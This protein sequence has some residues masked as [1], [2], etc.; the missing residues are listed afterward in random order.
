MT[1]KRYK[2]PADYSPAEHL[3]DLQ[4]RPGDRPRIETPAYVAK[5]AEALREAGFTDEAAEVEAASPGEPTKIEDMAP[6]DHYR[7]L[8]G[9][10]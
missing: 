1:Q 2:E 9:R 5:K 10:P 4:A 6:G 8:R 7:E 3:R